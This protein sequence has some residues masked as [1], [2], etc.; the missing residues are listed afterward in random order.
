MSQSKLYITLDSNKEIDVSALEQH[1]LI[2]KINECCVFSPSVE[3]I[4]FLDKVGVPLTIKICNPEHI[5]LKTAV[6]VAEDANISNISKMFFADKEIF[7]AVNEYLTST[8]IT[9]EYIDCSKRV[10]CLLDEDVEEK[11]II[12][13]KITDRIRAIDPVSEEVQYSKLC[14]F[15]F[16]K[17]LNIKKYGYE[18]L[19]DLIEDLGSFCVERHPSH[20]IISTKNNKPSI[21]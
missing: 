20:I 16:S 1:T 11:N 10:I 15:K 3:K 8:G 2:N 6:Q 9:S 7:D 17:E 18:K 12:I 14:G 13:N 21:D 4:V 19:V 5:Q